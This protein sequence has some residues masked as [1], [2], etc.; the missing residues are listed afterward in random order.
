MQL[1][2]QDIV[3]AGFWGGHIPEFDDLAFEDI[4]MDAPDAL[5]GPCDAWPATPS[6]QYKNN[7]IGIVVQTYGG[8]PTGCTDIVSDKKAGTDVLV[9]RHADTCIAGEAGCD[10]DVAGRLYF[11]PSFCA[12]DPAP[13]VLDHVAGSFT[14]HT[15]QVPAGQVSC[16]SPGSTVSGKRRLISNLYYI[17]D[18]AQTAGDG[19][20]TLM[21]SSFDLV[22]G[23]LQAQDEQALI[24]GVEVLRVEMG[25]DSLSKT[26]AAVE[27]D[28]AIVWL[29]PNNK[30]TATNRGDGVPDGDFVHCPD[31]GCTPE[32]LRNVVAVKLY[33][34]VRSL[35]STPGYV[36]QKTYSLGGATVGPFNDGFKRHVFTRSVRL[37]NVS[38]RRETP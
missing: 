8:V 10:A 11:Q 7:H 36:D 3:H 2:Q 25:I 30:S 38:G 6:A 35:Q 17:R 14:L 13:Y 34:L 16:N 15:R 31:T 24:E 23:V 29:D 28:A 26:G 27:H 1:L 32:Q 37:N 20:P 4:P 18:F 22:G 33:V 21:R 9:L 19:I 12:A 5:P